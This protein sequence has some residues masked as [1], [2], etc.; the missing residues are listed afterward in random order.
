MVW[1]AMPDPAAAAG[2]L[3]VNLLR[4][5][6]LAGTEPQLAEDL[7]KLT[8]LPVDEIVLVIMGH[9]PVAQAACLNRLAGAMA[10]GGLRITPE[11]L[12]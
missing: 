1:R 9:D 12:A 7:H 6:A 4:R 2:R 10:A 3:P 8:E 5:F 11:R